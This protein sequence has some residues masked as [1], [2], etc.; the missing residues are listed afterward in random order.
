MSEIIT[1][2]YENGVLRPLIPLPV[3]ENSTVRIQVFTED[4]A[5]E[6]EQVIQSL[7]DGG[8]VTLPPHRNDVEPVSEEAWRELTQRLEASE[9]KPLS[10]III[11]ERGLW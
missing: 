4:Q 5:T 10:E 8:L 7:V 6:A 1:A 9:S 2:V 3:Q 11:E